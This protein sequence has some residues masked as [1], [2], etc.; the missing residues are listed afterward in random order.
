MCDLSDVRPSRRAEMPHCVSR[1]S[2]KR[3]RASEAGRN[4]GRKWDR[5]VISNLKKSKCPLESKEAKVCAT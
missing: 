3:T 2:T 5:Q 1:K 4:H